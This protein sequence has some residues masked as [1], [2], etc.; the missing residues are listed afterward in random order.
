MSSGKWDGCC[1]GVL[2]VHG[3]KRM[4]ELE[5]SMMS[6]NRSGTVIQVLYRAW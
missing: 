6:H 3:E 5:F 1:S 4:V 2:Q